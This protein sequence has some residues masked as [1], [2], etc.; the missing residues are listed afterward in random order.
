MN[1]KNLKIGTKLTVGFGLITLILIIL[2]V[3]QFVKLQNLGSD[4]ND[5]IESFNMADYMME[6]ATNLAI[7]K[8]LVMEII[9]SENMDELNTWWDLHLTE[10]NAFDG[11]VENLLNITGDKSWGQIHEDDKLEVI[12]G[13]VEMDKEHDKVIMPLF[14]QLNDIKIQ[15]LKLHDSQEATALDDEL[16]KID[17]K[18]DENLGGIM[19]QLDEMELVAVR[20]VDETKETSLEGSI[21][22]KTQLFIFIVLGAILSFIF[23]IVII[24]SIIDPIRKVVDMT[25]KIAQGD[26]TAVANVKQND[27]VGQLVVYMEIMVKKLNEI[28]TSIIDGSENVLAGSNDIAGTSQELSSSSEQISQGAAEQASST[29]EVSSS[30]EEM[31]SNIQQNADN[32]LQTEKIAVEAAESIKVGYESSEIAVKSMKDIAEKILIINDI[33]FQTNILALNAAVEAARAGEHGKGFA[34]VAAEVRKLAERSK[35]AADEIG[36]VS[37][38]G[39]EIAEKSG[40]QLG[41][42]IPKIENTVK[43][44]QEISAASQE[45]NS[46][47]DQINGAIQQLS[48][49][50]QQ[51]ASSAE[52]VASSS[53]EMA[54]SAEELSGL[55]EQLKGMMSFFKVDNVHK[56]IRKQEAFSAPKKTQKDQVQPQKLSSL[57]PTGVNLDMVHDKNDP[58]YEKY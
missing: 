4:Q 56:G 29:E 17:K 25:E 20:I 57:E 13:I 28:V 31:S 22:A 32:S 23:A 2:G 52:E 19:E 54:S 21:M 7:E 16:S 38:A 41:D 11:N 10:I 5:L 18:L 40:V 37:K 48:G 55:A 49:V 39:V 15:R 14:D 27:E 42:V 47:V 8:Q 33:A 50:T 35:V 58:Q 34:V 44:V 6:A 26:L 43:L 24:R 36:V 1:F 30:M 53:E 46:G 12:T 9:A 51:N 3:T 45:Q